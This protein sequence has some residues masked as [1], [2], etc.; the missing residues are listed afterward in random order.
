MKK[1]EFPIRILPV[2]RMIDTDFF[3]DI[4][5]NEFREVDAPWNRI[6]MD[7]INEDTDGKRTGILFDTKE[8]NVYNEL[9]DPENM[10]SHVKLVIIPSL[11]DLDPVGMARKY[12]LADNAF[13][14]GEFSAFQQRHRQNTVHRQQHKKKKKGKGL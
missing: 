2:F 6:S 3:V 12:G 5:L 14:K 8:K 1:E 7:E 10:P 13:I 11:I 9:V 4:R